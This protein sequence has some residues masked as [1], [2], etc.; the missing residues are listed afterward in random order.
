MLGVGESRSPVFSPGSMEPRIMYM[1]MY[2]YMYMCMRMCMCMLHGPRYARACQG[3]RV[4][5]AVR[6]AARAP[7]VTATMTAT[8]ST[9]TSASRLEWG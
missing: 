3:A 8:S 9:S 5:P 7:R 1:Y 4:R 6:R 2:T